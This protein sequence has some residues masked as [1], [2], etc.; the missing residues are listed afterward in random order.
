MVSVGNEAADKLTKTAAV[1]GISAEQ[2]LGEMRPYNCTL[3]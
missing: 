3:G 1:H 2:R